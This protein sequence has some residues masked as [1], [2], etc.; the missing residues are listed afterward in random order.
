MTEIETALL[1]PG[2]I[3]GYVAQKGITADKVVMMELYAQFGK[4]RLGTLCHGLSLDEKRLLDVRY[5][6]PTFIA[7]IVRAGATVFVEGPVFL[8][9]FPGIRQVVDVLSR[10]PD[11]KDRQRALD[12]YA[13]VPATPAPLG[14]F[15]VHPMTTESPLVRL[16]PSNKPGI[17]SVRTLPR[18]NTVFAIMVDHLSRGVAIV[19]QHA[20]TDIRDLARPESW[21]IVA[22]MPARQIRSLS[23]PKRTREGAIMMVV[24]L[25]KDDACVTLTLRPEGNAYRSVWGTPVRTTHTPIGAMDGN[26]QLFVSFD[27]TC[28]GPMVRF[29]PMRAAVALELDYLSA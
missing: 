21:H 14:Q 29:T 8:A 25:T 28:S 4:V 5:E 12:I 2:E 23:R 15:M 13:P 24:R 9:D 18:T 1:L 22:E 19:M 26:S 6:S 17:V 20:P 10:I 27:D 11:A 7:S 3:P 16:N